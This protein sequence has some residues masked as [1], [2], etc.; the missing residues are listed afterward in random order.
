MIDVIETTLRSVFY[1]RIL[2]DSITGAV[3]VL[4]ILTLCHFRKQIYPVLN[5]NPTGQYACM[6]TAGDILYNHDSI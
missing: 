3:S 1:S 5:V 4:V 2:P 6:E